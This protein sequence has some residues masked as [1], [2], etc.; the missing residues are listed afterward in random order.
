MRRVLLAVIAHRL[1]HAGLVQEHRE[2]Q[3]YIGFLL[4]LEQLYRLAPIENC[5]EKIMKSH[6]RAA[7]RLSQPYTNETLFA[8][9]ALFCNGLLSYIYSDI[10]R[11]SSAWA[12]TDKLS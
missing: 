9:P 10:I 2:T 5:Q 8:T 6:H 1:A 7:P 4:R 12:C 11:S 3:H